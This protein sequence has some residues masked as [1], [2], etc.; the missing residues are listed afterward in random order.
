MVH[1]DPMSGPGSTPAAAL[2]VLIVDDHEGFLSAATALLTA[3]GYDVV[4]SATSGEDALAV[5]AATQPDV[6]LVDLRLPG[7]DGVEVAD[8][9]HQLDP[10]PRVVL[11]S[12]RSEARREPRVVAAPTVGFLS[13][14][15]LTPDAFA[16]LLR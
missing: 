16:A 10:S 1:T 3:S 4:G 13:K 12:S 7:I 8:R 11:I 9:L 2:R 15:E 6:V 14:S 5:V